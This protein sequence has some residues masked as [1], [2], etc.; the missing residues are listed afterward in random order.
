MPTAHDSWAEVYDEVNRRSFG[1]LLDALT[2]RTIDIVDCIAPGGRIL[3]LGAGTGRLALPLA[4]RGYR[5]TA[6]DASGE[7]LTK[8]R[9]KAEQ[10]SIG[11]IR[12]VTASVAD[13]RVSL[14]RGEFDL[15]LLVFSVVSY[16]VSEH[17]LRRAAAGIRD[18]LADGGDLLIDVP[19][20]ALFRS[21]RYRQDGLD[22]SV[23]IEPRSDGTF[24]YIEATKVCIG[25]VDRAYEDRFR[26]RRWRPDKILDTFGAE[27]F[28]PKAD[29]T[30]EFPGSGATYLQ[31]ASRRGAHRTMCSD[32]AG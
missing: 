23:S 5:V 28:T 30:D 29:R 16:L 3:D 25:D 8:L 27:G 21:A 12:T 4:Q 18:A 14:R 26:L 22:R 19:G 6:V 11:S 15:A 31:L 9:C 2:A 13:L 1:G 10:M 24:D 17:E 20:M 32:P 7:M